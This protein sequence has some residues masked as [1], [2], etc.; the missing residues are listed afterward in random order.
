MTNNLEKKIPI[1]SIN[2]NS[3]TLRVNALE[4]HE[5]LQ[6]EVPFKEWIEDLIGGFKG[7]H[8]YIVIKEPAIGRRDEPTLVYYI[9]LRLA[10]TASLKAGTTLGE[11][12][13]DYFKEK[14]RSG[15]FSIIKD[16][17]INDKPVD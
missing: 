12:A 7:F 5:Y 8:E 6:C 4:L 11:K 14:S 1:L 2:I 10:R 16:E 17:E 15:F 13:S 3:E 9:N